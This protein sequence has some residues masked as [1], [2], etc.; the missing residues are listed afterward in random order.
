[1]RTDLWWIW[2]GDVLEQGS[3]LEK[4]NQH[5]EVPSSVVDPDTVVDQS[6]PTL[7]GTNELA[8]LWLAGQ[9]LNVLVTC[10]RFKPCL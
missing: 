1:M 4:K 8:E 5:L 10:L 2:I 9:R 6:P 3:Q 7:I